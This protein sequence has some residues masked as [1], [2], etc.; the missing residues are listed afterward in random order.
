MSNPILATALAKVSKF[1]TINNLGQKEA[2]MF[3][4]GKAILPKTQPSLY[5]TANVLSKKVSMFHYLNSVYDFS[6][7]GQ[8]FARRLRAGQLSLD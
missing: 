3:T 2:Q 6:L 7:S 8:F 5:F 4:I 1:A